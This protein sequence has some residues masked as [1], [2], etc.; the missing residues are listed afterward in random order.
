VEE[1][2]DLKRHLQV[3]EA[4]RV[5]YREYSAVKEAGMGHLAASISP[6]DAAE[7]WD[8]SRARKRLMLAADGRTP[9][10]RRLPQSSSPPPNGHKP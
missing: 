10:D 4:C 1:V 7:E 5:L 6:N 8:N 2:L 9:R 3:C